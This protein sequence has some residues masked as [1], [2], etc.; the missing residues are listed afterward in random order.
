VT[1][2]RR[3]AAWAAGL[4][5]LL[6]VL[7]LT[8]MVV[9]LKVLAP[10]PEGRTVE[11]RLVAPLELQPRPEPMRRAPARRAAAALLPQ[12]PTVQPPSENPLPAAPETPAAQTS[13]G[14]QA[15]AGAK[16]LLPGFRG[17][18]GCHD[19]AFRL[20][21][22][23]RRACADYLAH[24]SRNAPQ[25]ALDIPARKLAEYDKY[26]RCLK[27]QQTAPVPSLNPND[28]SSGAEVLP[29]GVVRNL[30]MGNPQGCF[31]GKW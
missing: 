15:D 4:S 25:L 12:R 16:G 7:A 30:G 24:A 2:R 17:V 21:R 6:H 1:A 10:P 23:E 11:L 14:L 26:E 22:D 18:L 29:G 3:R 5:L 31:M 19:A 8:G 28:P 9:G 13:P 20:S 27:L